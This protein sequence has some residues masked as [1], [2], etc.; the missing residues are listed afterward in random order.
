MCN[1]PLACSY[2]RVCFFFGF[3]FVPFSQS[4]VAFVTTLVNVSTKLYHLFTMY[5]PLSCLQWLEHNLD[6]IELMVSSITSFL[7]YFN[8]SSSSSSTE[9]AIS[10]PFET[11][12]FRQ[13]PPW[14]GR[15][16][17]HGGP[18]TRARSTL[19]KKKGGRYG[20]NSFKKVVAIAKNLKN[21]CSELSV[22]IRQWYKPG[23]CS[24][25]VPIE[26]CCTS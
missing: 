23:S 19:T 10:V 25:G 21:V 22:D 24:T 15:G 13:R 6:R 14:A 5:P 16:G 1:F 2:A 11:F 17:P 12:F 9:A 7:S 20:W 3:Q 26:N 8:A 18:P 4:I